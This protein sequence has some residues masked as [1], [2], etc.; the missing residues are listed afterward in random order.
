MLR[1]LAERAQLQNIEWPAWQQAGV[2]VQL[3]RL[4]QLDAAAA[5]N[6]LFKLA[7]NLQAARAAG[8]SR[9]LSFGGAF[10]N[11]IHA[12]ALQGAAQG[13][14]TIGV[15][16]GEPEAARNPTLRDA[17]VAGMRLHFVDRDTYRRAHRGGQQRDALFAELQQ[18]F[19]RC[20]IIPEGAANGL[21][22]MGCRALGE[23][24]GAMAPIPDM[25]VLPCGTGATLAGIVAGLRDRTAVSGVAILKGG[26]F[27]IDDVR[28]YLRELNADECV[29][30][31]LDLD[32]DGG[33]YAKVPADVEQFIARFEQ[34]TGI[35]IEPVYTGKML[36]AV[37]R[38]I[39]RGE[40]ARGSRVLAIHTGGLQGARGFSYRYRIQQQAAVNAG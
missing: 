37:D 4:D 8:H 30:W 38:R 20:F 15:I 7:K 9:I 13:F 29:Y 10:S 12:L 3:W 24:I 2:Q 22:A 39:E 23:A 14:E 40:F 28:D 1:A 35:P 25:V 18:R 11:H 32:H 33:G 26:D 6:K 21:G 19:G 5:G 34:Q 31:G 17:E 36:Y 16:R 27:L